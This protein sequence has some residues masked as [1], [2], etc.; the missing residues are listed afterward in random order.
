MKRW[1]LISLFLFSSCTSNSFEHENLG[2]IKDNSLDYPLE[3]VSWKDVLNMEDK[4]YFAYVFSYDCYYC[5]EIKDDVLKFANSS[6]LKVYFIEYSK[7]I[8][9]GQYTENTIGKN[10]IE[11]IFIKGTPTLLL[12]ENKRISLNVAGKTNVLE[13]ISRFKNI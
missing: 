9:L 5:K 7:E 6:V 4:R 13:T 1:L 3:K 11:D 12:I 8:T 10:T 2:N